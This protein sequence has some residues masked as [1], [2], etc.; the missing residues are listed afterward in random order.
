MNI[1][2]ADGLPSRPVLS[3]LI[4]ALA[5]RDH[6]LVTSI[7]RNMRSALVVKGETGAPRETISTL[8]RQIERDCEAGAFQRARTALM[9]HATL[10]GGAFQ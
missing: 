8:L 10:F 6:R 5:L 4:T 9:R 7:V 1:E 3:D 2:S